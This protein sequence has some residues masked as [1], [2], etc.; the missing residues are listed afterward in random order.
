MEEKTYPVGKRRAGRKRKRRQYERYTVRIPKAVRGAMPS[1][2]RTTLIYG[3]FINNT[4][5]NDYVFSGN[6]CYDP[7]IT[8][9]GHQPRAFDQLMGL[10]D[11]YYVIGSQIEVW[12]NTRLTTSGDEAMI[13]V[14]AS[15]SQAVASANTDVLEHDGAVIR[16]CGLENNGSGLVYLKNKARTKS[17]VSTTDYSVLRGNGSSN[18]TE[19]WYWHVTA[20]G[21][22]STLAWDFVVRIKYD[23]V[24]AEPRQPGQS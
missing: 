21:T 1:R 2:L 23:V 6:G 14:L 22:V 12:A 5:A 9:V 24:F 15:D 16:Y 20:F 13:G 18:P 3:D 8:G 7:D 4:A 10:Y 11:H 19:S 17:Q